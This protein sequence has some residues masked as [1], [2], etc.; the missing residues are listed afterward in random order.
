[1][2]E[3]NSMALR[4]NYYPPISGADEQTGGGRMLGHEDVTVITLIPAPN[5]EGLQ[6]FNRK[7]G[8]WIRVHAPPGSILM[9]TGDYIQRVTNDIL[10]ST[11]HRVSKPRN[12]N[13][14]S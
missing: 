8:K 3:N 11:T 14:H 4:L 10:P 6:A 13:E 2:G 5:V 9:N 7:N 1:M 12:W